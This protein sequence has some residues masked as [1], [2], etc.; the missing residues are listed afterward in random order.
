MNFG[1]R[2]GAV[3]PYLQE[4]CP[5]QPEEK[6]Y[7]RQARAARRFRLHV[8]I[9]FA[10]AHVEFS[11]PNDINS[12]A[13]QADIG[14]MNGVVAQRIG[15]AGMGKSPADRQSQCGNLH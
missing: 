4:L 6:T 1:M 2:Y 11:V 7:Y 5:R 13:V 14:K 12:T 10:R 15:K 3:D 9:E 8:N